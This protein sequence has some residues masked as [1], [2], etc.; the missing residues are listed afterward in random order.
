M[1]TPHQKP[2]IEIMT[3]VTVTRTL[4]IALL[5]V[6]SLTSFGCYRDPNDSSGAA[7]P[8][9]P[10]DTMPPRGDLAEGALRFPGAIIRSR[11]VVIGS[12]K[13]TAPSEW[14]RRQPMSTMI[15]AEFTLLVRHE[16]REG[17][18]LTVSTAGGTIEENVD[19]WKGQ[20]GGTPEKESQETLEVEGVT[21]TWVDYTGT[22]TD[23]RGPAKMPPRPGYRML[24]AIIPLGERLYFVK[25]TGPE[26]IMAVHVDHVRRFLQSL[27][28]VPAA[29]QKPAPETPLDAP[30]PSAPETPPESGVEPE[31]AA[32]AESGSTPEPAADGLPQEAGP[33]AADEAPEA[34]EQP[35]GETP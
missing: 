32:P 5:V 23:Q 21:I 30:A 16:V 19:R 17:G 14:L 4:L 29:E 20:F 33:A 35:A 12:H 28:P 10:M 7:T 3:E 25:A 24:G 1:P 2:S 8:P 18:R 22:F 9:R 26:R 11:E 27:Q 6:T 34:G 13:L 31:S 15:L